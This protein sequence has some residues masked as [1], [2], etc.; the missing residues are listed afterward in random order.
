ML[1][2]YACEDMEVRT[3][4]FEGVNHWCGTSERTPVSPS[5]HL[6]TKHDNQ[7][8]HAQ[9]VKGICAKTWAISEPARFI[10]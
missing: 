4:L 7:R 3:C 5:N 6:L 1:H 2:M 8:N 10:Q 9:R